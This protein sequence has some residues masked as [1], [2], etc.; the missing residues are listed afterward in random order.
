LFFFVHWN[1]SSWLDLLLIERDRWS[2]QKLTVLA[3]GAN[4]DSCCGI[5]TRAQVKRAQLL[6]GDS[7][8]ERMELSARLSSSDTVALH[9]SGMTSLTNHR[10][11]SGFLM[12][13]DFATV[14]NTSARLF[15]PP[16]GDLTGGGNPAIFPCQDKWSL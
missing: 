14:M 7:R 16:A 4:S 10:F 3:A 15:S 12:A 2:Q 8:L 11:S 13:R 9:P 5:K 1:D 6:P